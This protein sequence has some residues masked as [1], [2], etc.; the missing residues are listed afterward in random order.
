M[1]IAKKKKKVIEGETN[2][3]LV[4]EQVPLD[5]QTYVYYSMDCDMNKLYT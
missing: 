4:S 5:N 3:C 1:D 2:L